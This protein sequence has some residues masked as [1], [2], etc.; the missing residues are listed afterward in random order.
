MDF[1]GDTN[2]FGDSFQLELAAPLT[3]ADNKLVGL[4]A[5][6]NDHRVFQAD[7]D[8]AGNQVVEVY[9][10]DDEDPIGSF[11]I[12]LV[13][14]L[15][16]DSI[17]IVPETINVDGIGN[18]R[19]VLTYTAASGGGTL[20]L[21]SQFRD[22]SVVFTAGTGGAVLVNDDALPGTL[23][24]TTVGDGTLTLSSAPPDFSIGAGTELADAIAEAGT[25]PTDVVISSVN[26]LLATF[27]NTTP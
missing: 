22:G 19:V 21:T 20:D 14:D 25:D 26:P 2:L 8:A 4:T 15:A 3:D 1:D 5:F 7:A 13:D 27:L 24:A 17:E 6:S 10:N 11:T 18:Y 12:E 16:V 23:I 9:A